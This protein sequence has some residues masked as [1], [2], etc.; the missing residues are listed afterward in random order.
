MVI[1]GL[2]ANHHLARAHTDDDTKT[3]STCLISEYVKTTEKAT[4][5]IQAAVDACSKSSMGGTV[6]FDVPNANYTSGSIRIS[7]TS[8]HIRIPK[9]VT[10]RA[11]TH[12][13]DYPGPQPS[14][15]L[16]H[17]LRCKNCSLSGGGTV[18]GQA[19]L[20]VTGRLA[21]RKIV[22]NFVDESCFNSWECRPRMLGVVQSSNVTVSNIRF[23]DPIYWT[24]HVISSDHIMIDGLVVR[25]D[26]DIFNN[27]GLDIDS[28]S[29]VDVRNCDIRTADDALCLKTT[30][31]G[32][33]L[34]VQRVHVKNCTLRSRAAAIKLGSE[35]RADMEDLLFE[36]ITVIDSHRGLAV[37]LRDQGSVRNVIFRRVSLD[38]RY[39]Q[40]A[41][42]GAS[43]VIYVT[44]TPRF[45]RGWRVGRVENVV[46]EDI[47][48]DSENGVF[49]SGIPAARQQPNE[50]SRVQGVTI[51][52]ANIRLR[53]K[54]DWPGGFQ[55]YRPSQLFDVKVSGGTAALWVEG[56]SRVTVS[57]VAVNY[58]ASGD[59]RRADWREKVHID[60]GTTTNLNLVNCTFSN[61]SSLPRG[62]RTPA[63]Q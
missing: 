42:W 10:L 62:N 33:G 32:R 56:A 21:D 43:E 20:Y 19:R 46:F 4:S 49:L 9:G 37:Q 31:F 61:S 63:S 7:G 15:Y 48:A 54:S 52:R 29:D 5:G 35:S 30:T 44:A 16:L 13:K 2:P 57:D 28:S 3:P 22:T 14:W 1:C 38:L 51:Q 12:R 40:F 8:V 50:T 26:W 11:G 60:I 18:D 53:K 17:F 39:E 59:A 58:P 34:P 41:W 23:D 36:D 55:D 25:G 6:L 24:V 47:D 27:D 45:K